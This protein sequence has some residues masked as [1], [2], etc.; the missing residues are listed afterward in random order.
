MPPSQDRLLERSLALTPTVQH[1]SR[2]SLEAKKP[3]TWLGDSRTFC[4]PTRRTELGCVSLTGKHC[5]DPT[6]GSAANVG[7]GCCPA[8]IRGR[9]LSVAMYSAD[10]VP[11]YAYP[12]RRSL[13]RSRLRVRPL[14]RI[15]VCEVL[16]TRHLVAHR[17]PAFLANMSS[18]ATTVCSICYGVVLAARPK[19]LIALSWSF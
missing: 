6:P 4:V 5:E 11:R 8:V 16:S 10:S 14:P 15:L 17:A 12:R 7:G 1:I 2:K 13:G 3:L 18:T 9:N 19:D